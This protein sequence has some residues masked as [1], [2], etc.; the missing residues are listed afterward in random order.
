MLINEEIVER[1]V[2]EHGTPLYVFD[3]EQFIVNYQDLL[4][5]FRKIYPKY[6][7]GYSYKTNYVPRICE[8]VKN[9][10]GYAEVVSDMEYTLAKRLGYE[11]SKIIYNGPVKGPSLESLLLNGGV[12]NIDNV[13]EAKRTLA[14]AKANPDKKI[15]VGIRVNL[16]LGLGRISR[17]GV[18]GS[19]TTIHEIFEILQS[20]DNLGVSG[21]HCHVS[22][23]R[24]LQAWQDRVREMLAIVDR[25][26]DE[27]PMFVNLGSGMYGRMESSF[28]TQFNTPIPSYQE[29]AEVVLA[30]ISQYFSTHNENEKPWVYTEPGTTLVARYLSLLSKVQAKKTIRG[31]EVAIMD[32]SF[33]NLGKVSTQKN[34]PITV[35]GHGQEYHKGIDLTGYTC[36]EEDVMYRGYNGYLSSGNIVM[37]GNI[38]AYSIVSKPPFI[39]PNCAMVELEKDG[40]VRLIK[41][42]ETFDDIFAT[43]DI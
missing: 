21:I 17:F 32:G 43:Y 31:R 29:Y 20:V 13:E 15:C 33:Y 30:P 27:P 7:I 11:D 39:Q 28:A 42:Q 19:N 8:I 24:D 4:S 1:L 9:L 23:A 25:Y 2:K 22:R 35:I 3:S 6:Q 12:S 10:G 41:R 40:S 16:D 26:F 5:T 18:D 14:L 38:G 36:L 34:L 37:F